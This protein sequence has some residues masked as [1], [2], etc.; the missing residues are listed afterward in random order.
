MHS[1]PF[2]I[3]SMRLARTIRRR[4]QFLI[5]LS[6]FVFAGIAPSLYRQVLSAGFSSR[7]VRQALASGQSGDNLPP[8]AAE[9]MEFLQTL[10]VPLERL[11]RDRS[12]R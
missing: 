12:D 2:D 8:E 10:R 4:R 6:L 7:Q 3:D 1:N 9:A 5:L 11:A